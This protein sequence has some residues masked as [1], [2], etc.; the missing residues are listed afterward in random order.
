MTHVTRYSPDLP[1]WPD[2]MGLRIVVLTDI[3]A[4]RPWMGAARLRAICDGANALAPDIVL[5]LGDY[6]SGPRF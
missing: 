4:C 2:A 6:A 3:H 5:L 1:G